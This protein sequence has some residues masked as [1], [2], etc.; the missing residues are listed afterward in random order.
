MYCNKYLRGVCWV[1]QH[2][3]H[4][5]LSVPLYT[6]HKSNDL[7]TFN[8][9]LAFKGNFPGNGL[10]KEQ[11]DVSEWTITKNGVL[12]VTT[13]FFWKSCFSLRKIYK[14]LTCTNDPND[15]IHSFRQRWSF[16]W[17]CFFLRVSLK[18]KIGPIETRKWNFRIQ[19][20]CLLYHS[21]IFIR[22]V[23]VLY[24]SKKILTRWYWK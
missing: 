1:C 16:I 12:P 7:C 9:C 20:Q 21:N 22:N 17:G 6:A 8:L 24:L 4:N 13:L 19:N 14:E 5:F 10:L 2:I 23:S 15:H 3:K 11:D 18:T